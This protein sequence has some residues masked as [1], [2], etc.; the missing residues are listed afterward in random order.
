MNIFLTTYHVSDA[1]NGVDEIVEAQR[2]F[3]I[4]HGVSFGDLYVEN[5]L[6]LAPPALTNV[7]HSLASSSPVLSVSPTALVVP[8]WSSL[9]AAPTTLEQ[10]PT[11]PSPSRPIA[12]TRFSSACSTQD[13]AR[14]RSSP[15]WHLTLSLLRTMLTLPSLYVHICLLIVHRLT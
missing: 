14:T 11:S 1:N 7:S 6:S 10:L 15:C 2:P 9:L 13:S 8:N 5:P 4:K 12:P 3:A